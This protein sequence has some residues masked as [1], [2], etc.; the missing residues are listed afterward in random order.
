MFS[1]GFAL[2]FKQ[3]TMLMK[4]VFKQIFAKTNV[5]SP[6]DLTIGFDTA[7]LNDVL[8]EAIR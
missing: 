7:L 2:V 1:V 3:I 8:F 4:N 6:Q 5:I